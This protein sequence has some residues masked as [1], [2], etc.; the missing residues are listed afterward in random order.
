MNLNVKNQ[1]AKVLIKDE[2]LFV[3]KTNVCFNM[4][5]RMN[6]VDGPR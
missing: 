1:S 4:A 5:H 6:E 3:L 2:A